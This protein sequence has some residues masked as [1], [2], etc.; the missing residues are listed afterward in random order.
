MVE[1]ELLFSSFDDSERSFQ[2]VIIIHLL[3]S[4]DCVCYSLLFLHNGGEILFWFGQAKQAKC[5]IGARLDYDC[6]NLIDD[7]CLSA[8]AVDITLRISS[9][10]H[11]YCHQSNYCKQYR[12]ILKRIAC[13]WKFARKLLPYLSS[14]EKV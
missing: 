4:A 13:E 6:L 12:C 9:T 8:F 10:Y 7:C 14:C 5:T 11:N 1:I 2:S 3:S